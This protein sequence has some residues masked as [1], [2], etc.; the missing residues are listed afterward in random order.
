MLE[1]FQLSTA[2]E[3]DNYLHNA[4]H[5]RRNIAISALPVCA[6]FESHL[7]VWWT[8]RGG[9]TER[10][11]LNPHLTSRDFFVVGLGR[12]G[13]LSKPEHLMK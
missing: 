1:N 6:V 5:P 11:Q 3:R 2:S 9:P 8:R 4:L 13:R 7:T 12:R 10:P